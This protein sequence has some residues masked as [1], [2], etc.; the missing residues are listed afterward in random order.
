[1]VRSLIS[2][3]AHGAR[4][5]TA[6]GRG[7]SHPRFHAASATHRR[8]QRRL[9]GPRIREPGLT[10]RKRRA[11]E[12]KTLVPSRMDATISCIC[13]RGWDCRRSRPVLL[14]QQKKSPAALGDRAPYRLCFENRPWPEMRPA[15]MAGLSSRRRALRSRWWCL[16][17]DTR[18]WSTDGTTQ[19]AY[20]TWIQ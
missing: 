19:L 1:M 3:R 15:R 11:Y 9:L 14:T 8:N 20:V 4:V 17:M 13:F 18:R 2:G 6:V 16:Q 5:R 12:D 10:R 7:R